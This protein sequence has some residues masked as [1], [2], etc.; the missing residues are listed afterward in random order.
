MI[1]QAAGEFIGKKLEK[2]ET[3]EQKEKEKEDANAK[4]LKET[5]DLTKEEQA[6]V[7]EAMDGGTEAMQELVKQFDSWRPWDDKDQVAE[8]LK[9]LIAKEEELI[10]KQEESKKAISDLTLE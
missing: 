2:N 1:G 8:A 5:A 7:R 4:V 10:R 3:L 9:V 6:R